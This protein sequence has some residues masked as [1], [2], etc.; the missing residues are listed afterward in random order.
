MKIKINKFW[1]KDVFEF[2]ILPNISFLFSTDRWLI[3][4]HLWILS[5]DI[6]FGTKKVLEEIIY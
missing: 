6:W 4:I 5:I 1:R 3:V 2:Q